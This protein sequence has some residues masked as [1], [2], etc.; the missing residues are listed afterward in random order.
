M[1][2]EAVEL[3]WDADR[4]DVQHQVG[5]RQVVAWGEV[6]V[7][8]VARVEAVQHIGNHVGPPELDRRGEE[9]VSVVLV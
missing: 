1:T 5:Q 3:A 9:P 8:T 6:A 4:P 2:V 7:D